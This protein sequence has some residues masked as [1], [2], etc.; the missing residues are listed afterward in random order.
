MFQCELV[1]VLV[2]PE[3]KGVVYL[4]ECTDGRPTDGFVNERV[5]FHA[6][7]LRIAGSARHQSVAR[8]IDLFLL[9]FCF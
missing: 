7:T 6:A 1:D 2:E 4:V 5:R 3:T 8:G 9:L